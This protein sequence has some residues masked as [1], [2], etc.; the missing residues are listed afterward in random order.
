MKR[1]QITLGH[2]I[3]LVAAAAIAALATR[4]LLA[5]FGGI[6]HLRSV[7]FV[8]VLCVMLDTVLLAFGPFFAILVVSRFGVAELF[9]GQYL[10][11]L[12]GLAWL[13]FVIT[14]GAFMPW[15]SFWSS[16]AFG[17]LGFLVL[18]GSVVRESKAPWQHWV[19]LLASSFHL[20][21]MALLLCIA[22]HL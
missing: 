2:V 12:Q 3:L 17:I 20:V 6:S 4:V 21:C 11:A 18:V 7:E 5:R 8:I 22:L 13:T 16:I 9:A 19:G 1:A 15:L 14:D 10:W